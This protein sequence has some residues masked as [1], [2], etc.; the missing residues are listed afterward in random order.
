[1]KGDNTETELVQEGGT[2]GNYS[3]ER[4]SLLWQGAKSFCR[5][6]ASLRIKGF[7]RISVGANLT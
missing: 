1:M 2:S 6:I 4:I 7:D 3:A 5:N